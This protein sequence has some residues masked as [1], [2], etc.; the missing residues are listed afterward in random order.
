[1]QPL[2]SCVNHI[3]NGINQCFEGVSN[4]LDRHPTLYKV[5]LIASHI[6]RAVSMY[7]FM[8]AVPLPLPLSCGIALDSVV[9]K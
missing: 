7:G 2:G 3:S 5:V 4:F 8:L 6:F 1:M 9:M